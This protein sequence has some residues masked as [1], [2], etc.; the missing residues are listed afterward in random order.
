MK[1]VTHLHWII[2]PLFF[3]ACARQTTPT[4]GPKDSIP[5][6]LESANYK[7]GQVNFKSKTIQLTF[8]ETIILNYPKEQ[9]L[10]TPSL[11]D[12]YANKAKKNQVIITL[13]QDLQDSTTYSI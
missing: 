4:G 5:P 13:E 3:L 9:L 1:I 7:R 8:S 12:K 10:I 6:S 11:G 2:Y